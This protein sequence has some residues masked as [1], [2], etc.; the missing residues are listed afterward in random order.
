MANTEIRRLAMLDVLAQCPRYEANE[1]FLA[2]ALRDIGNAVARDL[3]RVEL[4][5]LRDAGLIAVTEIA[6]VW[7]AKLTLRGL[8][9]ASGAT[10]IP[11]V[12]R[13]APEASR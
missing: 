8:D 5:W 10:V 12:H 3:L 1:A 13:P 7:I 9:A 2:I 11:G 6:D 4:A